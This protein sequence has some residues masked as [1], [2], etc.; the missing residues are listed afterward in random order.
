MKW[1]ENLGA[2]ERYTW[3]TLLVTGIIFVT[4]IERMTNKFHMIDF[5]AS[6]LMNVYLHIIILFIVLHILLAI[7]FAARR[8]QLAHNGELFQRDERDMII[9]RKGNRYGLWALAAIVEIFIFMMLFENAYPDIAM[10]LSVVAPSGIFFVLMGGV[11]L[12][13]IIKRITMIAAY[14]T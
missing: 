3:A 2:G 14:R 5:S 11:L 9:E 10:P 12:S 6:Q 7:V 1:K 4:F 13:D 8:G